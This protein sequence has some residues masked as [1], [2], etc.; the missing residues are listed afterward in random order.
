V[1]EGQFEVEI[2]GV[3]SDGCSRIPLDRSNHL[4]RRRNCRAI[5]G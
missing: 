4:E 3:G 1:G 2:N 5:R